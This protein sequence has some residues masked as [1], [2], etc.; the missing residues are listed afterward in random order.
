LL[1]GVAGLSLVA[2]LVRGAGAG[3]VGR[4]LW[5]SRRWIPV[6]LL[7]EVTQLLSDVVALRT[8]VTQR[9]RDIR[10]STWVRSSTVAYA[11]MVLLPAGRAAG[12]VARASLIARHV[13]GPF[14]ATAS[15]R[16]QTAYLA[17]LALASGVAG[18]SVAGS[19]GLR[20]PLTILLLANAILTACVAAGLLTLLRD[21]RIG[22]WL[23]QLRR[24][25]GG[26]A[27]PE[28][29][30]TDLGARRFPWRAL[31]ACS[32]GRAAQLLE[33]GI[34]LSAV[35]GVATVRGALTAH[36]IG[37]VGAT[38]GDVVPNQ[39]GVTDGAYRTFA[40]LLGLGAAPAR[41]LS[42]AFIAHAAQLTVAGAC[43]LVASL[44]RRGA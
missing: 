29:T 3:R 40:P 25:F 27:S 19:A 6:V 38:L 8:L 23:E 17:A 7:L 11:M 44:T 16:L 34:L 43:V 4:V 41:A 5:L 13:G 2:Y 30:A 36:G 37:L 31:A 26:N 18:A 21:A 22:G 35:G 9:T 28:P 42:I 33:Y 10:P 39:L 32:G 20:S 12:E 15:A 1:L 14:A 24:R